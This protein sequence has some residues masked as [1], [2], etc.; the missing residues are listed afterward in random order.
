MRPA[1]RLLGLALLG[2]CLLAPGT[3]SAAQS[4]LDRSYGDNGVVT[5]SPHLSGYELQGV[6]G[7]NAAWDGSAYA[8]VG[9]LLGCKAPSGCEADLYLHRYLPDGSLDLGFEGPP[10]GVLVKKG[11][12]GELTIGVDNEG[13]PLVALAEGGGFVVR[14]WTTSGSLDTGFGAGGEVTIP[15]G[16]SEMAPHF[17]FG[18]DGKIVVIGARKGSEGG[19]ARSSVMVSRLLPDG[20]FDGSFGRGGRIQLALASQEPPRRFALGRGG[21]VYLAGIGCCNSASSYLL[22]LSQRGKLDKRFD[23]RA[24]RSLARLAKVTGGYEQPGRALILRPHGRIDLLGRGRGDTGF[25]LRLR[26]DGRV[27]RR[28]AHHGLRT[29]GLPVTD[30]AL[31]G[32]GK[33]FVVGETESGEGALAFQL[34]PNDRVDRSFGAGKGVRVPGSVGDIGLGVAAL[35]GSRALV[36][37]IGVHECRQSCPPTPKLVRFR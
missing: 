17:V 15:C 33:S 13:R 7:M 3:A 27:E 34:L 6:L 37:D 9:G 20:R 36:I 32:G 5:V 12:S 1:S 35:S 28:F 22:R 19:G 29:I 30:A 10:N 11:Y 14:R 25:A 8:L 26:A 31:V 23:A 18:A 4:G 21:F 2:V 16:C 24:A